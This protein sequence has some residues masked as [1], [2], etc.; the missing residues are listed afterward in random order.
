VL[1]YAPLSI[2]AAV[3]S[4]VARDDNAGAKVSV[5]I[6]QDTDYPFGS[7]VATL[8]VSPSAA[9]TF[10]VALRIPAWSER[11]T[12]TVDGSPVTPVRP[13]SLL[14]IRR[15]WD[16]AG[17]K[18][19]IAFDFRLRCWLRGSTAAEHGHPPKGTAEEHAV[20]QPAVPKFWMPMPCHGAGTDD[21]GLVWASTKDAGWS[22]DGKAF[23]GAAG[24][25]IV[26]GKPTPLLGA[27]ASTMM[28][29]L[30]MPL[31]TGINGSIPMSFGTAN[32]HTSGGSD[33]CRAIN[34]DADASSISLH[35]AQADY[36]MRVVSNDEDGIVAPHAV[37]Q[38]QAALE[39]SRRSWHHLAATDDGDQ[40]S[41][42]MDGKLA[43]QVS[44]RGPAAPGGARPAP[45]TAG[46]FVV[47][48][49]Q[50][51]TDR[52]LRGLT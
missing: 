14:K 32:M 23:T 50:G 19:V 4:A 43:G 48:G 31:P 3:P 16:T 12:V 35:A 2:T 9:A 39:D 24:Q 26:I 52:R 15:A 28:C 18:I 30:S 1:L 34:I 42:Y 22:A 33:D 20:D 36:F 51:E 46:G 49:W 10:T 25:E 7:N 40:V 45:K 5:T 38:W 6:R 17:H 29:W 47:G 41:L 21:P 27:G 11:T 44:R 37:A 8:T 13:R